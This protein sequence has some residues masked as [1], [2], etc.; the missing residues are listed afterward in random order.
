MK[1][2][3]WNC[4]GALR[5][6]LKE[7][8]SLAADVLVIQECEDPGLSTTAYRD[9]A[10]DYLWVG[11]SKSRGLGVFPRNDHTVEAL[12]WHGKH[13]APGGPKSSTST[14]WTTSDLKLFLPFR[15]DGDITVLAVWTQGGNNLAFGYVGQLWK[16][17]QIHRKDLS[18]PRTVILGDFNSNTFWD[19]EDRWWNH[20]DVVAELEAQGLQ[21]LYHR[22]FREVQGKETRP[23]FFL[24]RHLDRPYHIDHVFVSSDLMEQSYLHIGEHA[25]W[26]KHSDHMPITVSLR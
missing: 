23:T 1:I 9:W 18:G 17:L 22:V 26:I 10:G 20:S 4:N 2:V 3:S 7:A 24:Y 5:N 16:Y 14:H 6:K 8:D 11:D 19:R 13:S 12:A 25:D 15:I 21:S